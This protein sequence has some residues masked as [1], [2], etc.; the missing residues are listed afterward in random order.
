VGKAVGATSNEHFNSLFVRQALETFGVPG[1][2]VAMESLFGEESPSLLPPENADVLFDGPHDHERWDVRWRHKQVVVETFIYGAPE[3]D[4]KGDTATAPKA[5]RSK[6]LFAIVSV[7]RGRIVSPMHAAFR[8]RK[9]EA[10]VELQRLGWQR[11]V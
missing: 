11:E 4:S 2:L 6:E 1:G 5:A 7:T 9:E 8:F 3:K 10:I